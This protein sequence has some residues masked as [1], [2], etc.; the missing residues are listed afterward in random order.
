LAKIFQENISA[1]RNHAG[2]YEWWNVWRMQ[3]CK[4]LQ[5]ILKT[6]IILDKAL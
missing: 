2:L 4:R 3:N 5:N 1:N 6:F